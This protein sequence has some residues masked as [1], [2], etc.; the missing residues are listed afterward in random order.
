MKNTDMEET[1]VKLPIEDN[2]EKNDEQVQ[3]VTEEPKSED[4]PTTEDV[5]TEEVQKEE[6]V[7]ES[8]R[9]RLLK[10][11]KAEYPDEE[12]PD[13]NTLF[14]RIGQYADDRDKRLGAYEKQN[15][16][17]MK[18]F[19]EEP[20]LGEF[21]SDIVSGSDVA[22]SLVKAYG[23][24]LSDMLSDPKYREEVE[25]QKKEAKAIQDEQAKNISEYGDN[26]TK[27]LKDKGL[28]E[29]ETAKFQQG[30]SDLMDDVFL[31]KFDNKV[32]DIL[33][34]GLNYDKDV[35]QAKE[36]GEITGR[37]ANIEMKKKDF[38][39]GVPTMAHT[40]GEPI[41]PKSES[42]GRKS[43]WDIGKE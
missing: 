37:N 40:S 25:Q 5:P 1:K 39:D 24:V 23:T 22:E 26:F 33:F 30:V 38:S 7:E 20:K 34:K 27:Y 6:P 41:K 28:D 3:A 2:K 4:A 14:I 10:R 12:F 32:M 15:S 19:E 35:E 18:L 9:D 13:D 43:V 8:P 29:E 21:F 11:M 42:R 31:F 17:L 36:E 16:S